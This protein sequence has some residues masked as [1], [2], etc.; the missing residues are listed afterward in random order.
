[1]IDCMGSCSKLKFSNRGYLCGR[2]IN[3]KIRRYKSSNRW[4]A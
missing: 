4:I 2:I 1:M 3:E